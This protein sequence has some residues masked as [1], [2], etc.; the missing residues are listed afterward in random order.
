M[1]DL[2]DDPEVKKAMEERGWDEPPFS[3]CDDCGQKIHVGDWP[4]CKG[5]FGSHKPQGRYRPFIAFWDPHVTTRDKWDDPKKGVYI[6][7]LAK[8]NHMMHTNG[9]ELADHKHDREREPHKVTA[10]G[11][12]RHFNEAVREHFGGVLPVGNFLTEDRD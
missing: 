5:N 9:W 10:P 2:W 4:I 1:C 3:L 8:W 12:D 6:D 11:F 7:S